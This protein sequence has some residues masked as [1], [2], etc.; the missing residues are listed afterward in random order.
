[1]VSLCYSYFNN[2]V[3]LWLLERLKIKTFSE[4][5][6]KWGLALVIILVFGT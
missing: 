3:V 4:K 5:F 1:M 2:L 6:K